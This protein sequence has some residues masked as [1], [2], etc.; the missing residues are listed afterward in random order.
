MNSSL[1]YYEDN[2]LEFIHNTLD[3]KMNIQYQSFLQD[4]KPKAH[5][6]DAGC[7]S[8]RDSLYFKEQGYQ[9]TAFDISKK[10]CDF[11]SSSLPF[12]HILNYKIL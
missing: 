2:A 5:I 4:L 11:A 9:I 12:I 8:G 3:K 6:L 10:M 1:K 7:G